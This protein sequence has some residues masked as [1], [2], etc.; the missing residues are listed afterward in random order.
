MIGV[1]LWI[2]ELL[3]LCQAH[4]Q[5]G[6]MGTSTPY[7]HPPEPWKF[8]HC[9]K[10]DIQIVIVLIIFQVFPRPIHAKMGRKERDAQR[11]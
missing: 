11:K 6:A 8:T 10:T 1:F 3:Y 5:G 2:V 9:S 4:K 7:L